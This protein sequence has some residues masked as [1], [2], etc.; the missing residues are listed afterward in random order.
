MQPA[1]R[2]RQ[3]AQ[4]G[5]RYEGGQGISER[6]GAIMIDLK[7][8]LVAAVIAAASPILAQDARAIS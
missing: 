5:F 1:R 7:I 4:S 3:R 2:H 8:A 6:K